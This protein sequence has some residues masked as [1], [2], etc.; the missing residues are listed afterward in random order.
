MRRSQAAGAAGLA[1]VLLVGGCTAHD[2]DMPGLTASPTTEST[3]TATPTPTPTSTQS[4]IAGTV[5]DLSDAEL[6]IVF[7]DVPE[8]SGDEADVY[9]WI[10]TYEVEVWRSLTTNEVSPGVAHIA[11]PEVVSAMER[12]AAGNADLDARIGGLF[13]VSVAGIQVD[14]DT[15][16]GTVCHDYRDVT[17]AD[18]AGEYTPEEAG[19]GD[20]KAATLTLQRRADAVGIWMIT[21]SDPTGTC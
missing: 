9:N 13:R 16:S 17:F 12:N 5:V 10:A 14:G 7:D 11:S 3:P 20:R 21:S 6:G 15:G 1:V 2:P 18:S 19:F 8:L 4:K